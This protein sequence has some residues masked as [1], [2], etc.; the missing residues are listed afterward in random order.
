MSSIDKL[1]L[2]SR[3]LYDQRVLEQRKEIEML[4]V[5]LFFRDYT[6]DIMLE[7]IQRLN[8]ENIRCKCSGCRR[9]GRISIFDTEDKEAV[10]TF[11]PWFDNVLHERG[12]I[13]L[14]KDEWEEE[15]C[16]GL[17]ADEYNKI[18]DEFTGAFPFS[19]NDCHLVEKPN[20]FVHGDPDVG[21]DVRWGDICIGERLWNV[22]SINNPWIRQ[23]E[24]VF[25]AP[26]KRLSSPPTPP[27]ELA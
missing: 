27:P 9:A 17:Y 23:F 22:E 26:R 20:L 4:K 13:V 19:D 5:K 21:C 25:G 10:C 11:G 12:L 7:A 1:A 8:K 6:L 24:R 3:L 15:D 14:R 2:T 18:S 16:D